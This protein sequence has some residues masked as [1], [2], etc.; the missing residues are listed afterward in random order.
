MSGFFGKEEEERAEGVM[1]ALEAADLQESLI[2]R[3]D[4][5]YLIL[6]IRSSLSSRSKLPGIAINI[7]IV[8]TLD[9]PVYIIAIS[10]AYIDFLRFYRYIGRAMSIEWTYHTLH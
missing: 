1:Q 5:E 3:E 6:M 9:E 7:R 4:E 8:D 10:V 2:G